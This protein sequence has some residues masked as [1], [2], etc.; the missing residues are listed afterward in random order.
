MSDTSSDSDSQKSVDFDS[1][2]QQPST[3]TDPAL[4]PHRGPGRSS[5]AVTSRQK[6]QRYSSSSSSSESDSSSSSSGTSSDESE[7][8]SDDEPRQNSARSPAAHPPPSAGSPNRQSAAISSPEHRNSSFKLSPRPTAPNRVSSLISNLA[9][10]TIGSSGA[11][12]SA[13]TPEHQTSAAA[14]TTAPIAIPSASSSPRQDTPATNDRLSFSPRRHM[15]SIPAVNVNLASSPSESSLKSPT[16]SSSARGPPPPLPPKPRANTMIDTTIP[17]VDSPTSPR[18]STSSPRD[19]LSFDM[20]RRLDYMRDYTRSLLP[21]SEANT[22]SPDM[23]DPVAL[24]TTFSKKLYM[25]NYV[26]KKNELSPDGKILLLSSKLG[27]KGQ[28]DRGGEWSKWWVELW[29]SVLHM[30]RVPDEIAV[31]TYNPLPTVEKIC[32]N[33]LTPDV[34]T[35]DKIKD[36]HKTPV[37]INIMDAVVEMLPFPFQ[38]S[39]LPGAP[40]P[41][42]VPYTNFFALSTSGSNVY[43]MAS[44]SGI[45]CNAWVAAIRLSCFELARLSELFTLKLLKRPTNVSAWSDVGVPPFQSALIKSEVFWEGPLQAR[46]PFTT[47]WREFYIVVSSSRLKGNQPNQTSSSLPK[48]LLGLKGKKQQQPV[49]ATSTEISGANETRRGQI[50]FY[51]TKKDVKKGRPLLQI[52][53]VSFVYGVW[54]EK[55]H[56]VESGL[57]NIFKVEGTVLVVPNEDPNFRRASTMLEGGAASTTTT[58]MGT[59]ISISSTQ[60]PIVTSLS[61]PRRASTLAPGYTWHPLPNFG[62]VGSL[63]DV[64]D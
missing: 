7:S 47:E 61:P 58:T 56:M 52:P 17:M 64:N 60:P 35:I 23:H 18:A 48:K 40:A 30:W 3:A 63:A 33:E 15:S 1:R 49:T 57:A 31:Q 59:G 20:G 32:K 27:N 62:A 41:P 28:P 24:F 54:P 6:P 8:D 19:A 22:T 46:F 21:G 10:V 9:A 53:E 25:S 45:Q 39:Q 37:Y 26:Y 51:E 44:Q 43:L 14:T 36:S 2:R 13:S 29:G 11:S 4:S 34:E 16:S 38:P 12:P 5:K 55:L 50:L 42:P